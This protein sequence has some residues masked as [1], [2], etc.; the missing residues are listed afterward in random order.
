M[1]W[2]YIS[3]A[4]EMKSTLLG[5]VLSECR[6][7]LRNHKPGNNMFNQTC[8]LTGRTYPIRQDIKDSGGRW[9]PKMKAWICVGSWCDSSV[10]DMK[11]KG[12]RV[13]IEKGDIREKLLAS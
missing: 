1:A 4:V 13:R 12:V 6:T 10:W 9:H 7:R 8:I 2:T 3:S 5:A 11:R